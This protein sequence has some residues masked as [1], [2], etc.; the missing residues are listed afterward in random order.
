[1]TETLRT[2]V[3][4][5]SLTA[6]RDELRALWH[7]EALNEQ[8]V[9]RARSHNLVVYTDMSRHN[10]E[11]LVEH[12]IQVNAHRPGR[13]ILVQYNPDVEDKLDAWVTVYCQP[14]GGHQVC[15]EMVVME[16]G[17]SLRSEVHGTVIS[18]LVPDLPV[19]LWWMQL[20]DPDD[21]LYQS[22]AA[23]ANRLIVDSDFFRNVAADLPALASLEGI[24]LGD[25][26]W[27]RL[28]PWRR[29][30][31]RF[32]DMP[33]LCDSLGE[34]NRLE[35]EYTLGQPYM[36][37]N[38]A[39]LLVGWL[40]ARLGWQLDEAE[41]VG[42]G[43]YHAVYQREGGTVDVSIGGVRHED[44]VPGEL[45]DVRIEAGGDAAPLSTGLL[46]TPEQNCI[47]V[48]MGEGI[49]RAWAFKPVDAAAALAQELDYEY[50]PAYTTALHEAVAILRAVHG[51]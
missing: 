50:D 16:V 26:A 46:L 20:P 22:L 36:D 23:E 9:I 38:R 11:N 43:G 6:I 19:Y 33:S 49:Q 34:I 14:R 31:A 27:S 39:L 48:Q 10:V 25:L 7:S 2:E 1:M 15:S 40:A 21:H 24:P 47:E 5:V 41:T 30:L 8:A 17:R 37:A 35:V 29:H 13:V 51:A 12:I 4:K 28:T 18:L 3:K 32:W 44:A 42:E 45:S